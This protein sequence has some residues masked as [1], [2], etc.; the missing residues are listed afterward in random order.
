MTVDSICEAQADAICRLFPDVRIASLRFHALR[1]TRKQASW[2]SH[3]DLCGYSS[4]DAV[5]RA[6]L[7]GI[8]SDKFKGHEVFYIIG[9]DLAYRHHPD[10]ERMWERYGLQGEQ[11][12]SKHIMDLKYP[13]TKVRSGWFDSGNELRGFYDCSKAERLLDWTHGEIP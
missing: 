10:D 1:H 9:P 7:A 2:I 13:G 3:R 11:R 4:Y 5:D 6:C 12:T 8:T